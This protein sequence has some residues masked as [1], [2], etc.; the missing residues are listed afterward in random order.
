MENNILEAKQSKYIITSIIFALIFLALT[1]ESAF[2]CALFFSWDSA[3]VQEIGNQGFFKWF[4]LVLAVVFLIGF[5]LSLRLIF[6]YAKTKICINDDGVN[7]VAVKFSS[8]ATSNYDFNIS[9]TDIDRAVLSRKKLMI[10]TKYDIYTF[11]GFSR[12]D[13]IVKA[14]NSRLVKNKI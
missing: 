11:N 12:Q 3:G 8:L 14:I 1:Y 9:F 4:L 13:E 6:A 2:H 10:Y 5:A 7:G